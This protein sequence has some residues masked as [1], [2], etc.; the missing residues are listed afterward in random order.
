MAPVAALGSNSRS[1]PNCHCCSLACSIL[2]CNTGMA[3]GAWSSVLS[4]EMKTLLLGGMGA[5]ELRA[6]LPVGPV[7]PVEA[8][9]GDALLYAL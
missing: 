3:P 5:G 9:A 2:V 6:A 4:S 1:S 7:A 8:Q